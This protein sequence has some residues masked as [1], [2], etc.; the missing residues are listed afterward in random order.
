MTTPNA[1][2]PETMVLCPQCSNPVWMRADRLQAH[3]HKV[4]SPKAAPKKS[5]TTY[6]ARIASTY[7]PKVKTKMASV[8]PAGLPK[9]AGL[10]SLISREGQRVGQGFCA[11]CG[12]EQ[13][14]LWHYAESSQGSVKICSGCKPTVFARSFG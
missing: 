14:V 3:L 8:R 10:F 6:T 11:E 1:D 4:H 2:D 5:F 9:G 13:L 7:P 12:V